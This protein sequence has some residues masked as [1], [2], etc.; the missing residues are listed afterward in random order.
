[1]TSSI[2]YSVPSAST[3]ECA[4]QQNQ[5]LLPEKK[6]TILVRTFSPDVL[7]EK[8]KI[9]RLLNEFIR[10]LPKDEAGQF[11]FRCTSNPDYAVTARI[12]HREAISHRE[13]VVHPCK[14]TTSIPGIWSSSVHVQVLHSS[15]SDVAD[16]RIRMSID[17]ELPYVNDEDMKDFATPIQDIVKVWSQAQNGILTTCL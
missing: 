14:F 6:K 8:E 5:Y 2:T 17:W 1:M 16:S 10:D 11:I 4:I 7:P 15:T 12:S 9:L 13:E 3:Q